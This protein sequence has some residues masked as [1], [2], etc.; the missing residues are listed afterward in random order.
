MVQEQ[1]D[2][3]RHLIVGVD[4]DGVLADQVVDVLPRIKQRLGIDLSYNQITEFRLPLG[5]TDLAA[6]I[7]DAQLDESYLREM[8]AFAGA[9]DIVSELRRTYRVVLIT[10]RPPASRDVTNAWLRVN[11]FEFDSIVHAVESKKSAHGLDVLV[12]DYTGNIAE[13]VAESE[14]LG[15]LLDRPWNRSD[16]IDLERWLGRGRAI[17]ISSLDE[18]PNR[19]AHY[20]RARSR[21]AGSLRTNEPPYS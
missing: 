7:R 8:P 19:L 13:F 1:S 3:D 20:E 14:G 12:D 11:H 21:S 2:P 18:L 17:V 9:A 5:D 10:A 16:R 6:E 4:L 15:I